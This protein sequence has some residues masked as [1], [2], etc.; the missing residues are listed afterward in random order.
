[1]KIYVTDDYKGMSRKA[2]NILSAQ[3]ILKPNS[4]LGLATGSTPE[5][6]YAQLVDWYRK[7]DLDFA[8]V[9]TVNLDEYVG[10]EPTHEQSY[11]Y[12]MQNNLF[13]HVNINP[14]NTNVPDGLVADPQAECDWYNQVIRKLG[15]IDIQVL[16]MGHNGHIGFNEPGNAFEL[17]THVVDLSERTIQANARFFASADEVPRQAMTM[18]IKSIMMAK[19]I[20]ML[21]SGEDKAEAVWKAFA[22]PVTPQV[23]ASILQ[24][25]PYVT[26]VGDKA[27]L[28]KLMEEKQ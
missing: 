1:M 10:L 20:L 4:V 23:P 16:G 25:H 11:R 18:G 3:V 19:K 24:L 14:A 5:G 6:M 7:G 22:G 17:E 8:A 27:A 15:G 12:F 28:S 13:D 21:V 2:A 9:K 26:L